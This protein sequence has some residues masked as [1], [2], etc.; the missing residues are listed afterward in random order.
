MYRRLAK[1]SNVYQDLSDRYGLDDPL[2]LM[3][4]EQ[5]ERRKEQAEEL[6][7]GERRSVRLAPAQWNQRLRAVVHPQAGSSAPR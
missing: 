7:F 5:V 6:P 2:V 3:L 1:I 4:K